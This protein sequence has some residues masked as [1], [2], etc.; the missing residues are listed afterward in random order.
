MAPAPPTQPEGTQG[1]KVMLNSRE[2]E[3]LAKAWLCSDDFYNEKPRLD[4]E[5]LQR[6]TH[7]QSRDAANH[8]FTKVYEK[9]KSADD[10]EIDR[11]LAGTAA[12]RPSTTSGDTVAPIKTQR[13]RKAPSEA[14]HMTKKQKQ[15]AAASDAA[16]S[17]AA[18][19]TEQVA[20]EEDPESA[21]AVEIED[22]K[23][24]AV[25]KVEEI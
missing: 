15:D 16:A 21:A 8:A 7:Y 6:I 10:V 12:P 23:N 19:K 14:D 24:N 2:L 3:I 18:I 11:A 22:A 20:E 4:Y 1:I 9:M 25:V 13:K 5:K 17:D